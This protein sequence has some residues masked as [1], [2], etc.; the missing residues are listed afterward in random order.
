MADTVGWVT[1]RHPACKKTECRYVG[2]GDLTYSFARPAALVVAITSIVITSGMDFIGAKDDEG[3]G[4][5]W[6]NGR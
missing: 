5:N 6:K 3:G 4:D 1:G 2:G